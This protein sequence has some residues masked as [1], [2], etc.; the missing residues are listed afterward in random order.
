MQ[1]RRAIWAFLVVILGACSDSS[2]HNRLLISPVVGS[3]SFD[4][5]KTFQLQNNEWSITQWQFFVSNIE[6]QDG[7]GQWHSY[8][9]ATNAEQHSGVALIGR[10]CRT[11]TTGNWQITFADDVLLSDFTKVRFSLGV[12][13]NI[14]HLNPIMQESPL[15]LPTMFWVW[16]TGH[17]FVR[18]EMQSQKENWIFHLGATGCQS[19]SVMR[20]PAAACR[21]TN[22]FTVESPLSDSTAII[23]DLS[24]LLKSVSV[25][26]Q[27]SCQSE[28]DNSSCQLLMRNI[29]VNSSP[30]VFRAVINE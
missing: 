4:C 7:K 9:L 19:P 29:Q 8:P 24:A 12:P 26:N 17:K 16:Q 6:L 27:T 15:N 2:Q 11:S 21:Y 1:F 25:S 10:N 22:L 14:N 18:I 20:A 13:F 5:N 30:S 28:Q 3:Q 23:F